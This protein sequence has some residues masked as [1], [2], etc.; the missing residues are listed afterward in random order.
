[1]AS[2]GAAPG[3]SPEREVF[4]MLRE[5]GFDHLARIGV[6]AHERTFWIAGRAKSSSAQVNAWLDAVCPVGTLMLFRS[7]RN[8]L[9]DQRYTAGRTIAAVTQ[10]AAG[11]HSAL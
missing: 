2:K 3:L 8:L 5:A 10:D 11:G 4:A 6:T 1:M 7:S 9:P